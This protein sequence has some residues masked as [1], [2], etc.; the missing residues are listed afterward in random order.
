MNIFVP[1][2]CF[3]SLF[4]LGANNFYFFP[5][6]VQTLNLLTPYKF[7]TNSTHERFAF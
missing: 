4:N 3:L 7:T 1:S 2:P 5:I 6:L